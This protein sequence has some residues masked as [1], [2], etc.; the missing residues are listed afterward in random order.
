VQLATYLDYAQLPKDNILAPFERRRPVF[1]NLQTA[2]EPLTD[3][4][5]TAAGYVSKFV[6]ACAVGLFGAGLNYL[7]NETVK[8]LREKVARFDLSYFSIA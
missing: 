4:Q 6:V 5:R 1:Q 2:L 3:E 7:W 8:S